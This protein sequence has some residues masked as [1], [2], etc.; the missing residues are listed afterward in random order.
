MTGTTP[1]Q[2]LADLACAFPRH[3]IKPETF[4]VYL[5]ELADLPPAALEAA[6]RELI[7]TSEFFPTVRAIREA[8]VERLLGLPGEAEALAQVE[9][10]ADWFK[11]AEHER[12]GDPPDVHPRVKEA[13]DHVGGF[14]A[15]RTA[16]NPSVVRGQFLRL[17][18]ELRERDLREANVGATALEAGPVRAELPR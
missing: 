13:L 8:A 1:Q 3:P 11:D 15:F 16:E 14:Y 5:R 17:Y 12:E 6:C 10:R 4:R 7:R 2:L 9:A 18:R